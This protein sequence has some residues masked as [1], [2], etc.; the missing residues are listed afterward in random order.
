MAPAEVLPEI[1][2]CVG[3]RLVILADSG[4]RRGSDVVKLLA[5]GAKA[6]LVGRAFTYGTAVGGEAGAGAAIDMLA[7]EIDRTM[8]FL[9]CRSVR[10]I[11]PDLLWKA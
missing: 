9:G 10:E 5:L 1:A 7:D 3:E 6:V 8:A 2:E 4:I 11:G